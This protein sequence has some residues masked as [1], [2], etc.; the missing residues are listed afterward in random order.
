MVYMDDLE[1]YITNIF[2]K[3][4]KQIQAYPGSNF[5]PDSVFGL[6]DIKASVLTFFEK[7]SNPDLV[8]HNLNHTVK[9]VSHAREISKHY[10]LGEDEL[11]TVGCAA[12][13]HDIGYLILN[14]PKGHEI[15]GAELAEKFLKDNLVAEDLISG[16]KACIMATVLSQRPQTLLQQILCDADLYHFGTS[17]LFFQD[18]LMYKEVGLRS[19]QSIDEHTWTTSTIR[20]LESHHFHTEYCQDLLNQQ[21]KF[22][23]DKLKL[24]LGKTSI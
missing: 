19:K 17:E 6:V 5:K 13:F 4:R 8:Y 15:L 3:N 22:N 14:D 2:E 16:V 18:A 21:K 24:I 23:L 11:F 7:N 1:K 20:L 10:G 9:V 12:W